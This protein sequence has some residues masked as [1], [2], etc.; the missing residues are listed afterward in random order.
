MHLWRPGS[1]RG[2]HSAIIQG[3]E[4][5]RHWRLTELTIRLR[6]HERRQ[7]LQAAQVFL[8]AMRELQGHEALD[9][10]LWHDPTAQAAASTCVRRRASSVPRPGSHTGLQPPDRSSRRTSRHCLRHRSPFLAPHARASVPGSRPGNL[11]MERACDASETLTSNVLAPYLLPPGNP[12]GWP[13]LCLL[14]WAQRC[15]VESD[16]LLGLHRPA[17]AL[18]SGAVGSARLA[19]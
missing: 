12:S 10:T 7:P 17:S 3:L 1:H 6:L 13:F 8:T 4:A 15:A 11:H 16:L 19:G 18:T 14:P 9:H 5:H 2:L